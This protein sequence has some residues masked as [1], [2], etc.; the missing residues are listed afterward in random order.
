M[1]FFYVDGWVLRHEP[2]CS[3]VTRSNDT[4]YICL[5]CNVVLKTAEYSLLKK[6]RLPRERHDKAHFDSQ[7]KFG[8]LMQQIESMLPEKVVVLNFVRKESEVRIVPVGR[9]VVWVAGWSIF[10]FNLAK[11]AAFTMISDVDRYLEEMPL[12]LDPYVEML[13]QVSVDVPSF[14]VDFDEMSKV[15]SPDDLLTTYELMLLAECVNA[16]EWNR[17]CDVVK[18]ARGGNYPPNWFEEIMASGLMARV[19]RRW[20]KS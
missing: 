3:V 13:S 17:A 11:A 4:G 9:E 10:C 5:T 7:R 16:Y 20:E 14:C 8:N 18:N 1:S 6:P 19:H 2:G 15:R 12:L